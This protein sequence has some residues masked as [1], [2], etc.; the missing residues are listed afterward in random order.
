MLAIGLAVVQSG[1]SHLNDLASEISFPSM[2][3]ITNLFEQRN[4]HQRSLRIAQPPIYP[5][6]PVPQTPVSCPLDQLPAQ[7]SP[8][9][10]S[11]YR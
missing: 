7:R 2:L 9:D 11:Q 5:T 10:S 3:F 6:L 8:S 4:F 1:I